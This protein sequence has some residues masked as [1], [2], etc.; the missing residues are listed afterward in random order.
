MRKDFKVESDMKDLNP[1]PWKV[2]AILMTYEAALY[3]V[4]SSCKVLTTLTGYS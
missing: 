3:S 4:S 2:T 1:E